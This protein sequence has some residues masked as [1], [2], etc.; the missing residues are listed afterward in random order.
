MFDKPNVMEEAIQKGRPDMGLGAEWLAW[1]S[2][3]RPTKGR[4]TSLKKMGL[5]GQPKPEIAPKKKS[6]K[7]KKSKI[8][9]PEFVE[10]HENT[11]SLNAETTLNLFEDLELHGYERQNLLADEYRQV[12]ES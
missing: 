11:V 3:S 1:T 9:E 4:E 5:S 6:K 10:T 8:I 2:G 7:D 12:Q